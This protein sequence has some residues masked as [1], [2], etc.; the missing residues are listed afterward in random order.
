MNNGREKKTS[1]TI[2]DVQ[3]V[4]NT[5][6]ATHKGYTTD[7]DGAISLAKESREIYPKLR[8]FWLMEVIAEKSL[9]RKLKRPS[10]LK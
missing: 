6:T 9:K 4:N 3:S 7:R 8:S 2:L 5:D 1:L 10:K